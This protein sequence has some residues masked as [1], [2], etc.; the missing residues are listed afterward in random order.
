MRS[1]SEGIQGAVTDYSSKDYADQ[2]SYADQLSFLTPSPALKEPKHVQEPPTKIDVQRARKI[3]DKW[4]NALIKEGKWRENPKMR[5]RV[6]E[7]LKVKHPLEIVSVKHAS[8]VKTAKAKAIVEILAK[9][10]S[11][12]TTPKLITKMIPKV[13]PILG[14][15][16]ILHSLYDNVQRLMGSEKIKEEMTKEYSENIIPFGEYYHRDVGWY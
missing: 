3:V 12:K 13:I 2:K 7:A 8:R 6:N 10:W 4:R 15:A 1:F 9:E 16:L 14:T 11:V 5:L